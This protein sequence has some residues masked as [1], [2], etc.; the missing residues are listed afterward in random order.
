M[1]NEDN[2][3]VIEVHNENANKTE[4]VEPFSKL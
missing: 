1:E 4:L 2:S 3:P